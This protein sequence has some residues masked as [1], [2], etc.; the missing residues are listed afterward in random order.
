MLEEHRILLD[1]RV[2]QI[3]RLALDIDFASARMTST[4]VTY[5]HAETGI[6]ITVRALVGQ[7]FRCHLTR[8]TRITGVARVCARITWI[9][10]IT[11]ITGRNGL[12]TRLSPRLISGKFPGWNGK[13]IFRNIGIT[14]ITTDDIR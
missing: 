1:R 7:G 4:I 9:T 5:I 6:R 10:W 3:F 12:S 8:I 2:N 11:W 14:H 13:D